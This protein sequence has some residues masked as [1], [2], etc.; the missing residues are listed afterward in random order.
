MI[1]VLRSWMRAICSSLTLKKRRKATRR[2]R[3]HHCWLW[4]SP[5]VKL[6]RSAGSTFLSHL[7]YCFMCRCNLC[8]VLFFPVFKTRYRQCVSNKKRTSL[9]F[10]PWRW[11]GVTSRMDNDLQIDHPDHLDPTICRCEMNCRVCTVQV[12]AGKQHPR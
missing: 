9:A 5:V 8:A 11:E 3:H 12:P 1:R 7:I 4:P 2:N 10:S 6:D